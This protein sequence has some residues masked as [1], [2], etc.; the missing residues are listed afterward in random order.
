MKIDEATAV[1]HGG[2]ET[3]TAIINPAQILTPEENGLS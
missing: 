2:G 1:D 3:T